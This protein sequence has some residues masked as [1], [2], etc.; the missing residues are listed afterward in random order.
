MVI[1]E[2]CTKVFA[3]ESFSFIS[4]N[5]SFSERFL[6][7]I[8]VKSPYARHGSVFVANCF[9]VDFS[10]PEMPKTVFFSSKLF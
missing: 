2:K 1:I 7:K 8:L 5:Y 10:L 4:E 3:T 9:F 6:C